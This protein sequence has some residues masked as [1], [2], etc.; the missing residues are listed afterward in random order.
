MARLFLV[1]GAL[2]V[3][4]GAVSLLPVLVG[5]MESG[6]LERTGSAV[7]SA[8]LILIVSGLFAIWVGFDRRS[9]APVPI[10]PA[11]RAVIAANILFLA[12]CMLEFSDG[13]VRQGGRIF[14]WT[15]VLFLPALLVLYG[16][17]LAQRWSW[18]VARLL[19][20]LATLWFAGFMAAIPFA[21]IRRSGEL[22]PWWG[23]LY[24]AGVTLVFAG[25]SAYVF[26]SLG[27][28]DARKFFGLS[29]QARSEV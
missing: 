13:L 14:Y 16:Q 8:A 27:R 3:L 11:V 28:A 18:W 22:I 25:V 15:S 12:V 20:A 5:R 4:S 2:S 19:A 7:L 9:L 6:A 17:V 24:M 29:H 21:D 23:R 10:P 1:S 26:H